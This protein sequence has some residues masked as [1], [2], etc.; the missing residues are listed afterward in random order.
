MEKYVFLFRRQQFEYLTKSVALASGALLVTTTATLAC[1]WFVKDNFAA[2]I[3]GGS[4]A[5]FLF[6]IPALIARYRHF[7]C[8]KIPFGLFFLLIALSVS[9]PM[10]G[11]VIRAGLTLTLLSLLSAIVWFFY[12]LRRGMLVRKTRGI[13]GLYF[14]M[15]ACVF[16]CSLFE[17]IVAMINNEAPSMYVTFIVAAIIFGKINVH[18]VHQFRTQLPEGTAIK[19]KDINQIVQ[20]TALSLYLNFIGMVFVVDF[21]KFVVK[22]W[23]ESPKKRVSE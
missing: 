8:N 22:V 13:V 6:F 18:D 23:Y 4:F 5:W 20:N 1:Y 14:L 16:V 17:A 9:L 10:F 11:I 7:I 2:S 21:M 12:T 3:F 19:E 15:L